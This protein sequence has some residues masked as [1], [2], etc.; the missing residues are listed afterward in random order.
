ME[1]QEKKE[2][3]KKRHKRKS[4]RNSS[5]TKVHNNYRL[6]AISIIVQRQTFSWQSIPEPSYTSKERNC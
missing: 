4:I 1:L 5:S 3:E 6:R 2:V